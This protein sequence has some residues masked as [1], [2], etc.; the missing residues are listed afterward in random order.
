MFAAQQGDLASAR[1]LLAAGADINAVAPKY[2]NAFTVASASGHE[3]VSLFLVENGADSDA[4]DGYGIGPLHYA[5]AQGMADITGVAPTARYDESYKVRPSN[6]LALVKALL[7]HGANPNAQIKKVLITFGTTVGLHGPGVPTMIGATPFLLAAISAD[8]ELMRILLASGADPQLRGQ[9]NTTPLMA[10]A[11][12]GWNGY[13]SEEDKRKA[14]E[15]VRLVLEL[16][17]DVN[18]ANATGFTPMHAG[19]HT[20]NDAIVRLLAEKGANVNA[21]SRSGETP[22]SMAEGVSPVSMNQAF[23]AGHKSTAALLAKLGATTMTTE[24]IA[25]FKRRG[26]EGTYAPPAVPSRE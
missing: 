10:A 18:E 13:R 17:V 5:V 1:L 14:V 16:G 9:G 3:A 19:A 21:V 22:W 8:V 15:A 23:Y 25:A 7:A 26:S 4:T 11:A 12:G 20:G 24:E 2:G 6:M